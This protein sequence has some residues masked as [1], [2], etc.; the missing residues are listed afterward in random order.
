MAGVPVMIVGE[1]YYTGL[2]AGHPI[3]PGGSPGVP[4]H[5]IYIPGYPAHPIY[6][7][8]GIWGGGNVPWPTPP[9]YYPPSGPVDPGYG[10]PIGGTPAHPIVLPPPRCRRSAT[11]NR[12]IMFRQPSWPPGLQWLGLS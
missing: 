6:N 3:A 9:I 10:V 12:P 5:P 11:P 4:A 8:P 1:L 2:T 7:P